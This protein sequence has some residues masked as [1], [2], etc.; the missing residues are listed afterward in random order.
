[1]TEYTDLLEIFAQIF[2]GFAGFSGVIAAFSTIRLAPEATAFR[3]RALVMVS[4]ICLVGSFL[5]FLVAAFEVSEVV[6]IRISAFVLGLAILGSAIWIWRQL[7]SLYAAHSLDTQLYSAILF[8]GGAA[9]IASL[10][11]VS[12]GLT[13][14]ISAAIY[15]SGLFYGLILCSYYFV[16]VIFAVEIK[17]RN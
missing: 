17:T 3:V 5:P 8:L 11:A 15:L 10:F 16:M 9:T 6:A 4:L 13:R 7:S 2:I 1:M 12:F 14:E